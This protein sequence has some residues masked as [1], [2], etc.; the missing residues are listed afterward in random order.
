VVDEAFMDV[1][2][3]G[4]SLSGD[5][6]RGNI[7]VLRS[8][9]KFFGLAGLRLGFALAAPQIVSRIDAMLG[10]WAVAG[11]AIAIGEIALADTAWVRA[12][13]A[14]LDREAR[15]L[16]ELL[17]DARLEIVGGTSLFRLARTPAA[18]KLFDHLGRAGIFV[19]RFS[20]Q[21]TWL[22]FGLPGGEKAWL[23]LRDALASVAA[24]L[25]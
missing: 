1:G 15:Q 9:G 14:Q 17:T 4:G 12:M 10:P 2:P 8:F 11:P 25:D 24:R 7:V 23:R 13:R 16:D 21:S 6:G 3:A 5:V 20:G 22:R 19:R 18:S